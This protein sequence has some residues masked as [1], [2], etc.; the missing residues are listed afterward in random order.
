MPCMVFL[1]RPLGQPLGHLCPDLAFRSHPKMYSLN[2]LILKEEQDEDF[3]LLETVNARAKDRGWYGIVEEAI[4]NLEDRSMAHMW[5]RT[6]AVCYWAVYHLDELPIP[7]ME[8]VA[9]LHWCLI[10]SP[11]EEEAGLGGIDNLVWSIA[12]ELKGVSYNSE[13]DPLKDPEVRTYFS[14]MG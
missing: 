14:A 4:A 2:E 6:I 9:R 8:M 13:W 7:K 12:I 3:D 11:D 5:N 1:E 10:N